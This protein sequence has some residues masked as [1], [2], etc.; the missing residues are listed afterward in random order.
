MHAPL[1]Q[2]RNLI[3]G[4]MHDFPPKAGFGLLQFLVARRRPGPHLRLHAPKDDHVLH[5]PLTG[6]APLLQDSNLIFGPTHDFP[7]KAGFGLLQ[8][9]V[10]RRRPGPHFL[11]HAPKVDHVLHFPSTTF[12]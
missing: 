5:F 9:L 10:N 6:H 7:P 12:A 2:L 3:F 11:L 8:F 4:P 1:L